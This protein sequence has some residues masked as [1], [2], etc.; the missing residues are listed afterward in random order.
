MHMLTA[1]ELFHSFGGIPEVLLVCKSRL[2][3]QM[4]LIIMMPGFQ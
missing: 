4:T 1:Q 3:G 2:G